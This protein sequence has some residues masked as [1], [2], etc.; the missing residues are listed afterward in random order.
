MKSRESMVR[1]KMFQAREKRR[2]IAQLQMMIAEF[3][4]MASDLEV[5]IDYEERKSGNSDINHFAYSP[6]ARAVRQRRDNLMNSIRE[7]RIQKTN[8]EI[9]LHELDTEL[10]Y[11]QALEKREDSSAMEKDSTTIQSRS[12]TG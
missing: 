8:A 11:A 10:Q 3:E 9:D 2:E 5:Q 12:M 4:R 1:L 7:L 6:F